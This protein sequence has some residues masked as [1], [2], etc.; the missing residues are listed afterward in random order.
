MPRRARLDTPGTL[1]HVMIRG[2]ERR[3][4]VDDVADRKNFIQRLGKLSADTKTTIYAVLM[5][6]V[7]NEWQ[8]RDYV[9]KFAKMEKFPLKN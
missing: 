8:D 1:Q 9:L 5:G 4:I 3:R 7:K 6:K 2:I